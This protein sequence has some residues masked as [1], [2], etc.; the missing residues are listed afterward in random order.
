MWCIR[1]LDPF[2]MCFHFFGQTAYIPSKVMHMKRLIIS[3]IFFKFIHFTVALTFATAA[4]L[5][6]MIKAVKHTPFNSY[7]LRY[8][9]IHFF[10]VTNLLLCKSIVAPHLSLRICQHFGRVIKNMQFHFENSI[11][12]EEFQEDICAKDFVISIGVIVSIHYV[13]IS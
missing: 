5:G 10:L 4:V 13:F 1:E 11:R 6:N 8:I 12:N 7:V 3:S 2:F 9:G